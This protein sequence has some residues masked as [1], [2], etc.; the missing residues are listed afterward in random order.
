MKCSKLI[1]KLN[2]LIELHGDEEIFAGCDEGPGQILN[3]EPVFGYGHRFCGYIVN[4]EHRC[5]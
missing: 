1:Y 5:P 4:F 2:E 3:V